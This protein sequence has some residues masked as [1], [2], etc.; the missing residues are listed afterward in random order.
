MKL[1]N[2]AEIRASNH[3]RR[4]AAESTA[5]NASMQGAATDLINLS[6]TAPHR[7]ITTATNGVISGPYKTDIVFG[8]LNTKS[9]HGIRVRVSILQQALR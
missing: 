7:R 6:M 8:S 9:Y 4:Q 3:Q 2:V 1:L 5:I